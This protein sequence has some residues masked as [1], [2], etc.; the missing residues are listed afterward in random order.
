MAITPPSGIKA[1]FANAWAYLTVE[2][3][4]GCSIEVQ[5]GHDGQWEAAVLWGSEWPIAMYADGRP[6]QWR[7]R[8]MRSGNTSA[9]T[10]GTV[11][12]PDTFTEHDDSNPAPGPDPSPVPPAAPVGL[13][14]TGFTASEATVAWDM[15]DDTVDY[16]HVR[17]TGDANWRRSML[18]EWTFGGLEP[19]HTYEWEVKA[20]RGT[21][22]S[23]ASSAS[24]TF[25]DKPEP[26]PVPDETVGT[27]RNV[28]AHCITHQSTKV[29][30]DR[31]PSIHEYEVW[32][33]G[34]GDAAQRTQDTIVTVTGLTPLTSYT[35]HVVARTA[36]GRTSAP[37]SI[38]FTTGS[39]EPAPVPDPD[40]DTDAEW[41]APEL[42]VWP[43]EGGRVRATWTDEDDGTKPK[44]EMGYPFWHVS[45]DQKTWYFT[46][47][48]QYEFEVLPGTE[49]MVS[50]YGV[51]D[52]TLTAIATK[53][54]AL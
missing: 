12:Y 31:D 40:V 3:R 24:F 26:D 1:R 9:W 28:R 36:D 45:L 7:A 32:I 21:L 33:D 5:Q 17:F 35:A 4:S 10:T 27:P 23:T 2:R 8:Y 51:W 41:P 20:V 43:L 15:V 48:R 54:V 18:P 34:A 47:E 19:G 52:N 6:T 25:G 49:V 42:M 11:A 53:G 14:T 38:A 13:R 46:R 37:G 39:A 44:R 16:W 22:E 30:W 50:V 29:E